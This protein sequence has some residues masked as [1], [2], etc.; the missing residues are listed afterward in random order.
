MSRWARG[1]KRNEPH[2]VALALNPEMNDAVAALNILYPQA[3]EFFPAN[4][5]IQER[6]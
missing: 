4:P 5:V 6:G 1:M 3:A 2:L